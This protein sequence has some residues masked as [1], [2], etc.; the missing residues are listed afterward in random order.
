MDSDVARLVK[1]P[2]FSL[3]GREAVLDGLWWQGSPTR[4]SE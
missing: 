1:R 4:I 3:V 2:P